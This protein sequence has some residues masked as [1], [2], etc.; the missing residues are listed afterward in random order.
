MAGFMNL[1]YHATTAI[2][3]VTASL[4]LMQL[5]TPPNQ[6]QIVM[7]DGQESV[8]KFIESVGKDMGEEDY[9]ASIAGFSTDMDLVLSQIARDNN[10]IILNAKAV[11]A[12]AENITDPVVAGVLDK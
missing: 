9:K 3:A 8:L 6:P 10:L 5:I 7:V 2:V 4:G 12:G 1:T 11:L